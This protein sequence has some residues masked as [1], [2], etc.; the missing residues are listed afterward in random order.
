MK[1]TSDKKRTIYLD[2]A[3][4]TYLDEKV[5][6]AMQPYYQ[7][8]FGNPSSLYSNGVAGKF[9][10]EGARHNISKILN[11][12][13]SEIIFTAGG[14]E[15][16]NMAVFGVVRAHLNRKG[17]TP[18][19]I[20]SAI[21]HH[22]VLESFKALEAE[23]VQATY[24]PVDSEGFVNIKDLIKAIKSNTV[25]VS[26]IYANNEIGTIQNIPELSKAVKKVNHK[27]VFHT[28]ACQ[29]AGSLPL[30]VNKLSVDL[31]TINGSKI[32]GPKQTGLLYV[33]QGTQLTP[34]IY[35]GGQENGLRSGTENVPGIVG[36][37]TALEIAQKEKGKE[38][39]RLRT[40]RD[41]FIQKAFKMIPNILLNGPSVKFDSEKNPTRLPNNINFSIT[42][43]EGEALLL[44]LDA[45]GIE[46]STG[47]AC[48]SVSLDPSHVIRAIGRS[49]QDAKSAIRLTLGK[50]TTKKDLDFVL[51]VI[52]GIV[53]ELRRVEQL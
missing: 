41:Y 7:K 42:G 36:L 40:L 14:T 32:Y 3:A 46:I 20:C 26:I 35:G 39:K 31:M 18:H 16:D 37:A 13:D 1:F 6:K 2:H 12:K 47:S 45:Q 51:K 25:L 19:I 43:A 15:S 9:A 28:D 49:N 21:E 17:K 5:V 52:P 23:G 33:R 29:A 24:L 34:L 8:E 38:N 27:I 30:D 50:T 53:K 48:A 22:A 44:Y 11:C 4:T 10:I